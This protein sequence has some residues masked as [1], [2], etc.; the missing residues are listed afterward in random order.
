MIYATLYSSEV[1]VE[2]QEMHAFLTSLYFPTLS[3]DQVD[4]LDAPITREEIVHIIRGVLSSKAPGPDGFTVEFF[5]VYAEE[6][7]S[8]LL[9]MYNDALDKDSLPPTL[10]EALISL[11]LQKDKDLFDCSS[12]RPFSLIGCDSKILLLWPSL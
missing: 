2:Q 8:L 3:A 10:S 7:S 6:L 9:Q 4:L 5:K 11:I 1:Q 12:Y